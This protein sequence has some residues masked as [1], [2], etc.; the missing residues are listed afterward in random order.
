MNY[1]EGS[2]HINL[3][4]LRS[5]VGENIMAKKWQFTL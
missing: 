2:D 5:T 4:D 1:L 3:T